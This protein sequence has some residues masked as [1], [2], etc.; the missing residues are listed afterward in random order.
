M[1]DLVDDQSGRHAGGLAEMFRIGKRRVQRAETAHGHSHDT[2]LLRPHGQPESTADILHQ[3]F[4]HKGA[5]L[6][7]R[8][9]AVQPERVFTIGNHYR[10]IIFLR[11]IFGNPVPCIARVTMQQEKCSGFPGGINA[12]LPGNIP[13]D[14]IGKIHFK[15]GV[16]IQGICVKTNS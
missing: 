10:E 13:A 8:G 16:P 7:P 9:K 3:F 15:S 2:G 4:S 1:G 5:V 11:N 12:V 6:V 14:V